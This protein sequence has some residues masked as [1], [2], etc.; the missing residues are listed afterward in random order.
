VHEDERKRIAVE[1]SKRKLDDVKTGDVYLLQD[2]CG[3]NLCP[4]HHGIRYRSD[5]SM[6]QA[7]MRNVRTCRCDAKGEQQVSGPHELERTDARHTGGTARSSDDDWR[8]RI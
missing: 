1:V 2:Q 3:G 6:H 8:K 4:G 7:L 5:V